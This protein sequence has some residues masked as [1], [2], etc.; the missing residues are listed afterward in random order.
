MTGVVVAICLLSGPANAGEAEDN[1]RAE[2]VLGILEAAK[3]AQSR[4]SRRAVAALGKVE[5]CEGCS[6]SQIALKSKRI[7]LIEPAYEMLY[8]EFLEEEIRRK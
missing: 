4:A 3:A 2:S 5:N 1:A 6:L 8:K 7:S